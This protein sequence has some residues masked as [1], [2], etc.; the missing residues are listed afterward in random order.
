[1]NVHMKFAH[2]SLREFLCI[3]CY[4]QGFLFFKFVMAKLEIIYKKIS[5]IWL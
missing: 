5:Q 2:D 1:M 4:I 3:L